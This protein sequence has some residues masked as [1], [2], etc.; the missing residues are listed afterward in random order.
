MSS[1]SLADP[2]YW[3]DV[4]FSTIEAEPPV[5]HVDTWRKIVLWTVGGYL[6]LNTG[7][8]MIRVPPVGAGIPIGELV[9]V[10]SLCFINLFLLLPRIAR[11][12]WIFPILLWW[13]MSL[14]RSLY[15][16]HVGGAWSFRDASQ[17]IESLFLIV[18]FWLVNSP[19]HIQYFLRWMRRLFLLAIPY[20]LLFP[21]ENRLQNYSPRLPGMGTGSAH[22]FFQ[23]TNT[24]VILIWAACWLLIERG[25]GR[26]RSPVG[27]RDLLTGTLVAYAVAFSQ[28]RT[29]YLCVLLVGV[30]LFLTRSRLATRW[31]AL[32]LLGVVMIGAVS[33]S[34][35]Q[36]KGR[37]GKKISLDF[38]V[39]HFEAITGKASSE[40]TVGA[41][42]GVPQRIGWWRAIYKKMIRSPQKIVFGLGYGIPLT[43]YSIGN[44]ILV[45]EPHNSFV[46]VIARLGVSGMLVW[47]LMQGSLYISW[48]R[49][50]RFCGRMEW[51][52]DR[53]N[54]LLLLLFNILVVIT[55]IGEDGFEKPF[56]AIPYYL[57]FGV[58]LRYGRILREAAEQLEAEPAA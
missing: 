26:S 33:V 32:L 19:S 44:G 18:G 4:D 50:Y 46:S 24:P 10:L 28:S 31:T 2:G 58:I 15:D 37:L 1:S 12:V 39:S 29:I 7:F 42:E 3:P 57:F 16:V 41:A 13:G 34:G 48:W 8:E 20:G 23:M 56:Y 5:P 54:L 36:I 55:A 17:A 27:G 21:L 14:T 52:E 30:M 9:L 51:F 45:R 6:I 43:D 47:L 40:E 22:L 53:Q 25:R 38:I 35:I 11:E 49:I